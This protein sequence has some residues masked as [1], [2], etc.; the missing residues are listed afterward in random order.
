[1]KNTIIILIINLFINLS[2]YADGVDNNINELDALDKKLE[3]MYTTIDNGIQKSFYEILS[4]YD[5]DKA[6]I[7]YQWL[8]IAYQVKDNHKLGFFISKTNYKIRSLLEMI[9]LSSKTNMSKSDHDILRKKIDFLSRYSKRKFRIGSQLC[10]TKLGLNFRTFPMIFDDTKKK[11]NKNK[12]TILRKKT[13]I[14]LLYSISYRDTKD[15]L[16]N[17]GYI[18]TQDTRGWINIKYTNCSYGDSYENHSTY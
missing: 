17:W 16:V 9:M 18:E 12:V 6:K 8:K 10:R 11:S 1:M 7:I 2:L 5:D 15:R 3:T 14:R 4:K 13:K